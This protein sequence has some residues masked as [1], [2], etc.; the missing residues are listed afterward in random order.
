MRYLQVR[1]LDNASNISVG[2]ARR[3]INY[4]PPSHTVL[5]RQTRIYRYE[6][7]AGQQLQA[8]VEVISGDPDLY[9]WSSNPAESARVSNNAAGNEQVTVPVA[10]VV[11][12]VYQIEVYGYSDAEYHLQV[13]IGAP[14]THA[15]PDE[16]Q[17]NSGKPQ[18]SS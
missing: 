4:Q 5:S 12:G 14:T 2:H 10:E 8:V 17:T 11:A 13:T 16:Q 1:A 15:A 3:L 18:P 7:E 9:V 6:V